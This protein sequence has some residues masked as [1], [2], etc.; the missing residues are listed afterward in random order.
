MNIRWV[1]YFAGRYF[2]MFGRRHP[3]QAEL[4]SRSLRCG[5]AVVSALERNI[6]SRWRYD[7]MAFGEKQ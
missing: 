7:A 2:V 3:Q 5:R 6:D 4:V 1:T